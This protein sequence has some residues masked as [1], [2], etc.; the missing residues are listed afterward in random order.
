MD[1]SGIFVESSSIQCLHELR[2]PGGRMER[3]RLNI[4]DHLQCFLP[5][6]NHALQ[7]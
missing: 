2:G 4:K 7:T 3:T 6:G 5:E 1:T